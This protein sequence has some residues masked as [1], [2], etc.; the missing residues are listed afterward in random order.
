M[1]DLHGSGHPPRHTSV[2]SLNLQGLPPAR[3]QERH[4]GLQRVQG[5]HR[6]HQAGGQRGDEGGAPPHLP[7]LREL[8]SSRCV[9]LNLSTFGDS[10]CS[11]YR[12]F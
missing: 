11:H 5:R 4:E 8:K 3:L 6:G 9:D 1:S 7:R 10:S 12:M 2:F